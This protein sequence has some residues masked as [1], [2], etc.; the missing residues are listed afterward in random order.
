MSQ[1]VVE[2]HWLFKFFVLAGKDCDHGTYISDHCEMR[3]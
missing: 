3:S 1:L 2:H